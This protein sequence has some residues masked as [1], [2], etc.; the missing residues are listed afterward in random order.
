MPQRALQIRGMLN[1]LFE[2]FF[3]STSD[4]TQA[5]F[6]PC[7]VEQAFGKLLAEFADLLRQDDFAVN[8]PP[9]PSG[10][11]RVNTGFCSGCLTICFPICAAMPTAPSL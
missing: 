7:I 3:V 8:T 4:K 2:Y 9:L 5:D 6:P 10:T 1:D 11:V